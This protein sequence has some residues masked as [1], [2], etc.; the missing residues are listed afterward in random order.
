MI[1]NEFMD[2]LSKA[3][4]IKLYSTY[5][6]GYI[7]LF[8]LI[9]GMPDNDF[10]SALTN[11]LFSIVP[12]IIFVL[13]VVELL[14]PQLAFRK[15]TVQF[16]AVYVA[17]IV[18]FAF[19][20]RLIDNYLIISYVMKH[21][22]PEPLFSI[23]VMLYNILKLQFVATIP[24]VLKLFTHFAE[25]K[26]KLQQILAEKLQAELFSLRS[27]L[28]PHFLFNVLNSLYLKILDKSDDSAEIVLKI[29]NLLRFSIYDVNRKSISLEEEIVSLKN[30]IDLQQLRF[31]NRLDMS[32]S[33]HGAV[34]GYHI[35][36]FLILPF[37][38]NSYK[39]CLNDALSSAWITIAVSTNSGWL[40]V[41]IE[42]SLPEDL[43]SEEEKDMAYCGVGIANVQRRLE[44]LYPDEHQLTIKNNESSFFVSLK[45]KMNHVA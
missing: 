43:P 2:P 20:Q 10:S 6:L 42:N 34:N 38:E 13:V 16:I 21:W 30:Y 8:S 29:S 37:V 12:R 27:Q 26:N 19:V 33:V 3:Q 31:D 15:K 11:E 32:L 44:L 40:T 5:W 45:L 39:Y 28:Q 14:I 22:M 41:K 17:L 36:P 18:V 35:E 7:L 1:K 25:Q 9:Q 23:P 24:G 4:K